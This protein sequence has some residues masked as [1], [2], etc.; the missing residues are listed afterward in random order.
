MEHSLGIPQGR[1]DDNDDDDDNE[2]DESN[3]FE[4]PKNSKSGKRNG[5]V[6]SVTRS[7]IERILDS[8]Q[9]IIETLSKEIKDLK[10]IRKSEAGTEVK[11]QIKRLEKL[12]E[13]KRKR[14]EQEEFHYELKKDM[15]EYVKGLGEILAGK[16]G[17]VNAY[18]EEIE[19]LMQEAEDPYRVDVNLPEYESMPQNQQMP[20]QSKVPSKIKCH[21]LNRIKI[22]PIQ[23]R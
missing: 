9:K 10:E 3:S 20:P 5:N 23:L 4:L 1:R 13:Q 11:E 17:N 19:N 22:F 8:Q 7:D 12:V 16:R 15:A 18:S 6:D 2:D 21:K 14:A